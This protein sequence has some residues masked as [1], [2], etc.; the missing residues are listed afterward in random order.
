MMTMI[1][2]YMR[3]LE[4]AWSHALPGREAAERDA[5]LRELQRRLEA[6]ERAPARSPARLRLVVRD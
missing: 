1:D 3:A 6:R 4:D 2:A 5:A